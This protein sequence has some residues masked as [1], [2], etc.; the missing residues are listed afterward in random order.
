MKVNEFWRS[1]R[2]VQR[3]QNVKKLQVGNSCNSFKMFL[4]FLNFD[5]KYLEKVPLKNF[6]DFW[7]NQPSR[8]WKT[9]ILPKTGT[10]SSFRRHLV[11]KM[12]F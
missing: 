7:L 5:P 10:G 3:P 12:N 11:G 9:R 8:R 2:R 6:C 4:N 1:G